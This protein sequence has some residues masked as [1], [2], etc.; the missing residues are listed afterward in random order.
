[1]NRYFWRG[2]ISK[3]LCTVLLDPPSSRMAAH[4][5]ECWHAGMSLADTAELW[6]FLKRHR[7]R[8]AW[9]FIHQPDG[10]WFTSV[11]VPGILAIARSS[12]DWGFM[13]N[14]RIDIYNSRTVSAS[15][16]GYLDVIDMNAAG[17]TYEYADVLMRAGVHPDECGPLR[18]A[19]V[20]AAYAAAAKTLPVE[21]VIEAWKTG[22]PLEYLSAVAA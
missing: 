18:Q 19:G 21:E 6:R 11:G 4:Y 20:P 2:L 5:E 14:D 1:M 22:F 12:I 10:L 16:L 15:R 9:R 7:Q 13:E 17:V 8:G 3:A